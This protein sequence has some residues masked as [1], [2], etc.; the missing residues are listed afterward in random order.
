MKTCCGLE[1]Q[2][3]EKV[4]S[5]RLTVLHPFLLHPW[6]LWSP[7]DNSQSSLNPSEALLNL[8]KLLLSLFR[9][10]LLTIFI[11]TWDLILVLENDY[12]SFLTVLP[13]SSMASFQ[14]VFHTV[15]G[16]IH[17]I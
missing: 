14:S 13:A 10:L 17:P 1:S 5:G 7:T 16:V 8:Y 15:G 2:L 11:L 12:S 4:A 9:S 3:G 6:N